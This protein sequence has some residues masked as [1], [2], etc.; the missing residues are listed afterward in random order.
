MPSNRVPEPWRSFLAE[1]DAKSPTAIEM[2]CIGGFAVILHYGLGRPTGDIDVWH[3]IPHDATE[4]LASIAGEGTDLHE[5][6][7][8]HLQIAAVATLPENYAE[9]LTEVFAGEFDRLRILVLDPY[10]LALSKLERN[11]EVDI[12]D[13]KHLGRVTPFDFAV[14]AERYRNELR[15]FLAGPHS[16]HD[17][18][19]NLWLEAMAE[20]R[21]S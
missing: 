9:R 21:H 14:F 15:P 5:K 18:T 11:S 4:W 12:E 10:D 7:R 16:R 6:Y 3:V 8:V 20:E 13:V 1:V 19:L 17:L 2:H